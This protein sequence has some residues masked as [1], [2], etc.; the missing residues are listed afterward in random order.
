MTAAQMEDA[1][2]QLKQAA[3]LTF[4]IVDPDNE[5]HLQGRRPGYERRQMKVRNK[6]TDQESFDPILNQTFV[7]RRA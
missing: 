1:E 4:H 3:F 5:R 7:P 6:R 2:K